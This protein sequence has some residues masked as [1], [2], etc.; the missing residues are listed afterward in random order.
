MTPERFVL[1]KHTDDP[2]WSWRVLDVLR[3]QPHGFGLLVEDARR[4]QGLLEIE[5]AKDLA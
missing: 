5:Y 1:E 2:F 3:G 4:L